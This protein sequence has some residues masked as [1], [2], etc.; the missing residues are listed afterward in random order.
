MVSALSRRGDE[1]I[2]TGLS[3][4]DVDATM[5]RMLIIFGIV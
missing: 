3:M 5:I 1:L 4:S 2:V